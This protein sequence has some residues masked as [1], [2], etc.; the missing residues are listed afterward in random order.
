MMQAKHVVTKIANASTNIR[1]LSF[2]QLKQQLS[3]PTKTKMALNL[4]NNPKTLKFKIPP[5][6][7]LDF[8]VTSSPIKFKVICLLFF[9]LSTCYFENTFLFV[10]K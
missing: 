6:G 4:T 3:E 2:T 10:Y 8:S 5:N 9:S 1:Q 7:L